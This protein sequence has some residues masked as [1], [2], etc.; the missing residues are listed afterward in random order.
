MTELFLTYTGAA[1]TV[2]ALIAVLALVRPLLQKRYRARLLSWLW[3]VLAVRLLLPV[4]FELPAV[5]APVQLEMPQTE[6]V[7]LVDA[8][9]LPDLAA[10]ELPPAP[11]DSSAAGQ[12][13]WRQEQADYQKAMVEY[14][15][16]MTEARRNAGTVVTLP[17]VLC[18]V[19]L[20]G[21]AVLAVWQAVAYRYEKKKLLKN[22]V[23]LPEMPVMDALRTEL[24]VRRAVPVL[25]STALTTPLVLGLVRPRLLLPARPFDEAE[26]EMVLRHELA[27]IRR[28][29]I[30]YK[31][32][33]NLA[34]LVHWY[35]PLVWLARRLAAQDTELA[36]DETVLAGK[37][38]AYRAAYADSVFKTA[39]STVLHKNGRTPLLSTGFAND[40]N[41]LKRRFSAICSR[42]AKRPGRAV[43]AAAVCIALLAGG[44][45][46]VTLK[47]QQSAKDTAPDVAPNEPVSSEPSAAPESESSAQVLETLQNDWD[48]FRYLA[49]YVPGF[50]AVDY[51][52]LEG[53][54]VFTRDLS[55]AERDDLRAL[56]Q[57]EQWTPCEERTDLDWQSPELLLLDLEHTRIVLKEDTA[58]VIFWKLPGWLSGSYWF[59]LPEGASAAAA[60]YC[61]GLAEKPCAETPRPAAAD[62]AAL[63]VL[64][65]PWDYAPMPLTQ[66]LRITV[67]GMLQPENWQRIAIFSG[68]SGLGG[69][70][71]R[72]N[73]ADGNILGL[74]HSAAWAYTLDGKNGLYR[75]FRITEK[76]TEAITGLADALNEQTAA[77]PQEYTCVVT[78][79]Q[80]AVGTYQLPKALS[81]EGVQMLAQ[82]LDLENR[83]K[84]TAAPEL[85]T[86]YVL[87]NPGGRRLEICTDDVGAVYAAETEPATAETT[88]FAL[89]DINTDGLGALL[90]AYEDH[91]EELRF[92]RAVSPDGLWKLWEPI[93]VRYF[94]EE[95][96]PGGYRWILEDTQRGSFYPLCE[97]L[98]PHGSGGAGFWENGDL[99]ITE[100]DG[101]HVYTAAD[102]YRTH[103][104]LSMTFSAN[105]G[106]PE[107][108]HAVRRDPVDGMYLVLHSRSV[109]GRS[110]YF[111]S[112]CDAAGV[113]LKEY[114]TGVAVVWHDEMALMPSGTYLVLEN[115]ILTVMREYG[116]MPYDAEPVFRFDL[117]AGTVEDLSAQL[118][119]QW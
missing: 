105:F 110:E 58:L 3:L 84:V 29:D 85:S 111:L 67:A 94:G 55:I 107:L 5:Q 97:S 70:M 87:Y 19:W 86:H 17:Q 16:E 36:C 53:E 21:I 30:A 43:L 79:L 96:G 113:P 35:D 50:Q 24:G 49:E 100:P 114:A 25:Q 106:A 74:H 63:S 48:A 95:A 10:P 104:G 73:D 102:G 8:R 72:L 26:L 51:V 119:G 78:E 108:L 76:E 118:T 52:H 82:L 92:G 115:N 62:C 47:P 37:N 13:A 109:E 38:T 31:L 83:E 46:A 45:A 91:A 98:L 117:T 11:E 9:Q 2:S 60:Q 90:F 81:A 23:L 20:A 65:T 33:M 27:H 112:E 42:V 7:V 88:V 22:A 44:V 59:A 64:V 69:G 15:Q 61:A 66:T 54:A 28:G 71:I 116:I 103:T 12:E 56:V 93:Q 34:V 1:L 77:A 80:S 57:P 101:L 4:R 41:S 40:K 89:D 99:Y 75:Q 68:A 6:Y 39:A 32:V 18:G 14:E